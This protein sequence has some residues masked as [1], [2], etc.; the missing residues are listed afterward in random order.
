MPLDR[1]NDADL[2]KL[3]SDFQRVLKTSPITNV[4][5]KPDPSAATIRRLLAK[6]GW[7]HVIKTDDDVQEL[8]ELCGLE[9]DA[10]PTGS[11]AGIG[12]IRIVRDPHGRPL[13]RSIA[14][15]SGAL[16]EKAE[17][18]FGFPLGTKKNIAAA[19]YWDQAQP[20]KR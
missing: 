10:Y 19:M 3:K 14:K 12:T 16:H 15:R 5:E 8:A 11:R 2:L 7:G 17:K 4:R 9:V 20:L 1:L 13:G 18:L 6:R